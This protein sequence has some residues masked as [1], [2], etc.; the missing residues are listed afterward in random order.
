ML[1]TLYFVLA[2]MN[3][4]VGL[5]MLLFPLSWY[6]DFPSQ[7]AHT[8]AFNAHFVRDLGVVFLTIALAFA[9]CAVNV[10]RARAVH[11]GITV[12]FTG[13]ALIH[14]F[15]ILSGRLP[16]SHWAIDTPLVFLPAVFLIILAIPSVRER[17]G[18]K[19]D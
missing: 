5:W 6:S 16:A 3:L 4:A 10:N 9:W 12:F 13:H 8:G 7:V 15:D 2:V 14:L 19:I 17:L 11:I 18:E 1:K